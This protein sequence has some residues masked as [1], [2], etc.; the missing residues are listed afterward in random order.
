MRVGM[1][2]GMDNLKLD[3]SFPVTRPP[4]AN[5][6]SI[7]RHGMIRVIPAAVNDQGFGR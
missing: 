3:C 1:D 2:I 6:L 7:D 4:P 5:T